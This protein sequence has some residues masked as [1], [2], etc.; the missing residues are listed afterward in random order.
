MIFDDAYRMLDDCAKGLAIME[1]SGYRDNEMHLQCN[2]GENAASSSGV[3]KVH[4]GVLLPWKS[5][6]EK[7]R[8]L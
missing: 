6:L 4:V 8:F 7:I 3:A 5:S 1:M 2:Q